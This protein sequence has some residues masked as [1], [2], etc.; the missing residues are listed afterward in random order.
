MKDF[1][2][3][4][5]DL[6]VQ[7]EEVKVLNNINIGF[8]KGKTSVIMGPSGCG[9]ST[10]L[11]VAAGIIPPEGGKVFV[12]GKDLNK[13]SEKEL[14]AFRKKNSFVFQD[15][16]LWANKSIFQNLS[17]PLEFHYRSFSAAERKR[18]IEQIIEK[19]GFY[20]D[21]LLRPSQL[22]AGECKIAS[23]ARALITDPDIIFMDSP[24]MSVDHEFSDRIIKMIK[25]LKEQNRTLII[26]THNPVLTS[27][28]ADY[29]YILK[30]GTILEYGEFSTV[31]RSTNKEVTAILTDVLSQTSTFDSDIL[32]LLE[33]G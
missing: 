14:L 12:N 17:L 20:D 29:L 31:V 15:A 5:Q 16:A 24:T 26:S 21:P 8:P 18:R 3:E 1:T 9:K 23:F 27:M 30:K 10:L 33:P 13:M 22:S 4:L 6:V 25:E 19:V 32:N 11:K 7:R 2:I 28:V